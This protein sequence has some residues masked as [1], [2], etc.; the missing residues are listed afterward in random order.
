VS[1]SKE[2]PHAHMSKY[3]KNMKEYLSA[4]IENMGNII[5]HGPGIWGF[6]TA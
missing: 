3:F 6:I 4:H 5:N 1:I 2:H